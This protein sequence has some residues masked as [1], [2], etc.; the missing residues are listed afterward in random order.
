MR[1]KKIDLCPLCGGEK[2]KAKTT[3]TVDM[4][5]GVVVVRDV[6]A[7]VCSQCGAEW[8]DDKMSERVE[9]IVKDARKK[10]HTVE[11]TSFA[12]TG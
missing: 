2:S 5:F 11:V 3:F 6:P 4:G 8:M 7:M 10:H 12:K 9:N 1:T